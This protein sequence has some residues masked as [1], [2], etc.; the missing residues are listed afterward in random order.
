VGRQP[1]GEEGFGIS[2][3][4]HGVITVGG[5]VE[6][7]CQGWPQQRWGDGRQEVGWALGLFS[8]ECLDLVARDAKGMVWA[9]VTPADPPQP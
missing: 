8:G 5:L 1:V 3:R 6:G 4:R 9:E 7:W 2:W